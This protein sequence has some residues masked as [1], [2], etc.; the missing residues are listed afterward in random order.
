M[1]TKENFIKFLEDTLHAIRSD[2]SIEGRIEYEIA[3][4]ANQFCVNAFVRV[5]NSMGQGGCITLNDTKPIPEPELCPV[6]GGVPTNTCMHC[7]KEYTAC[8]CECWE[9][10]GCG[11]HNQ[12]VRE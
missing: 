9:A 8:T 7:G 6:C 5:G 4:E 11:C 12:K 2:D 10:A 1:T 3:E